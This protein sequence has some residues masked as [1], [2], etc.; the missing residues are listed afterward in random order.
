MATTNLNI[1][2]DQEIP[3]D[4]AAASIEEGRK[5]TKNPS[6]PKYSSIDALKEALDV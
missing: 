5:M 1:Y 4:T 6:S 2:T 3:N